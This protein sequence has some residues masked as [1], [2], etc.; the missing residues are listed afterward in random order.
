MCAGMPPHSCHFENWACLCGGSFLGMFLALSKRI[1]REWLPVIASLE[2]CLLPNH[3][4]AVAFPSRSHSSAFSLTTQ[5]SLCLLFSVCV[6]PA[7][8]VTPGSWGWWFYLISFCLFWIFFLKGI[9]PQNNHCR[10]PWNSCQAEVKLPF[11]RNVTMRS[12]GY[13]E[14]DRST[15]RSLSTWAVHTAETQLMFSC[16]CG[17]S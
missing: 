13:A 3:V 2:L 1:V 16:S 4:A 6:Y 7:R 9:Q 14:D 10:S 12:K 11:V 15:L 5:V 8:K 17:A